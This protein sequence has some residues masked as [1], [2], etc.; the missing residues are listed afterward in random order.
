MA[1]SSF[2]ISNKNSGVEITWKKVRLLTKK[3]NTSDF[4]VRLQSLQTWFHYSKLLFADFITHFSSIFLNS[5]ENC[6]LSSSF[7]LYFGTFLVNCVIYIISLSN[8]Q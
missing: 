2:C 3:F 4:A 7:S 1:I 6:L 5:T 8:F